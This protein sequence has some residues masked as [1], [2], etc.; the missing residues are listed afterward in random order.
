MTSLRRSGTAGP[1]KPRSARN[2]AAPGADQVRV[3]ARFGAISRGMEQDAIV[4]IDW[5]R[6]YPFYY[7]AHIEGGRPDLRFIEAMPRAES[8]VSR[9]R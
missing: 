5:N 8:P 1:G 2:T 6:L 3:R 9:S 4:F 7:A